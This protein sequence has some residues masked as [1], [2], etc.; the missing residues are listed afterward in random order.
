MHG[1]EDSLYTLKLTRI[2]NGIAL[3]DPNKIYKILTFYNLKR[4][5]NII[6]H[7]SVMA[8]S[9]DGDQIYLRYLIIFKYVLRTIKL[10]FIIMSVS[11]FLGVIWYLF[12][13]EIYHH[14][15]EELERLDSSIYN[16][17]TFITSFDLDPHEPKR[18]N[19][20]NMSLLMYFAYTTLSTV[21]FGD[22]NPRSDSER[23]FCILI[24]LL[25]VAI[26]GLI[27]GNF[28]EIIRRFHNLDHEFENEDE[29]NKFFDT[30][31]H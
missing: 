25:G 16:T 20:H 26:F 14:K 8:N 2:I 17:E 29:L 24:L 13:F 19:P 5:K 4:I 30:L 6:D 23:L 10:I 27:L 28:D 9:R 7:N 1:D 3:L 11:Y 22:F 15:E 31:K 21:G 12:S 18:T